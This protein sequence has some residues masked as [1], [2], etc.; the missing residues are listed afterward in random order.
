VVIPD[1]DLNPGFITSIAVHM[2]EMNTKK[3]TTSVRTKFS[4]IPVTNIDNNVTINS[5]KI[6]IF[7]IASRMIVSLFERGGIEI[8]ANTSPKPKKT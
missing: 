4:G 2:N 3:K 6:E 8:I 7:L 5:A 1:I